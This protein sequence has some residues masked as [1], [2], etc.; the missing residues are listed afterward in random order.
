MT[1][2]LSG[3]LWVQIAITPLA[4]SAS[5]IQWT[6]DTPDSF[7]YRLSSVSSSELYSGSLPANDP[8]INLIVGKRYGVTVTD[9]VTHPFQIIA[10]APIP[11]RTSNYYRKGAR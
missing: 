3:I 8:T 6:F 4:I 7:D 10:K 5:D 11:R 2:Y 1:R 9:P